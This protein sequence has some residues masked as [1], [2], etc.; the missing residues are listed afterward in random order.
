MST[1]PRGAFVVPH[2][3]LP[4]CPA[5][6]GPQRPRTFA[7][8]VKMLQ[9][10]LVSPFA[11]STAALIP[12]LRNNSVN[13]S[14]A[15]ANVPEAPPQRRGWWSWA[16]GASGGGSNAHTA[17]KLCQRSITGSWP[18]GIRSSDY[19]GWFRNSAAGLGGFI[20]L[21]VSWDPTQKTNGQN[22][23]E[24]F[25][26]VRRSEAN[27]QVD[28][29]STGSTGNPG[30]GMHHLPRFEEAY[31]GRFKNKVEACAVSLT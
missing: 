20:P 4:N 6:I 29:N 5:K 18:N 27:Y 17:Q 23:W 15:A 8:L 3:E 26:V 13:A 1:V 31:V 2:F 9:L 28:A 11:A 12:T 22:V 30:G 24:P 25:V 7:E 19:D 14:L 10:G 16:T 21:R